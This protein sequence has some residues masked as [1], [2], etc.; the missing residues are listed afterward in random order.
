MP[1]LFQGFFMGGFECS[2]HRRA[3]GRRLD[4]LSSTQHDIFASND[5]RAMLAHGMTTVRDG[6]RWHLIEL[7]PGVYDWSSF[8]PQLR[9]AQQ[10]GV[11]PIWDMCHYG[12]P[13]DLDVWSPA[14]V[15]RFARFAGAMAALVRDE[16]GGTPFYCPVNEISFLAWAGGDTGDINPCARRRGLEL[17]RQLVRASIAAIEAIRDADPRARIV[18]VDPVINIVP[19][20]SSQRRRAE[21]TRLGQ[22]QAWDMIAG[23]LMP[24]LGGNPE[25]LDI[26]GV[27]Y[28][29][30][31]QWFLAGV[32][33]KRGDP[34][35]RPFRDILIETYR[36][37]RRPMFIAETGAEGHWRAPW[38]RYVCDEVWAAMASGVPIEGICLYPVTDYP[39]WDNDRHCPTGLLGLPDENG[40]RSVY[41]ELAAEISRQQ[42]R[43]QH[44]PEPV[45]APS[46]APAYVAL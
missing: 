17:K 28:Y 25:Y 39:G 44:R 41:Q 23:Q 10:T 8:L 22:Y 12:W 20:I 24:E 9:A 19:K 6:A 14:F 18:N 45:R 36:R 16:C 38:M 2:S 33:I 1:E 26:V 15:D 13:D 42:K 31:N 46:Y 21:E 37:Y 11:Q 4:L 34:D 30:H 32:T 27:N 3:D 43:F 40:E 29:P 35:Y 5:Y 7:S